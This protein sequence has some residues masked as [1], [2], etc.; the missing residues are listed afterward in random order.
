MNNNKPI[1]FQIY[2][3]NLPGG[4]PAAINLKGNGGLRIAVYAPN[5]I[6]TI[7]GGPTCPVAGDSVTY[8]NPT[9]GDAYGSIVGMIT[10]NGVYKW[11]NGMLY[12]GPNFH[13]DESLGNAG[14]GNPFGI[15]RWS[16]LTTF[17]QRAAY[18]TQLNF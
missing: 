17:A 12:P 5:D 8:P 10:F 2:T 1:D 9:C 15:K 6:V 11:S 4:A 7:N 14:A 16:E 13:Y 3:T 18:A